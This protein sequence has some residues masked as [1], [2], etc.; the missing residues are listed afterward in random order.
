MVDGWKSGRGGVVVGME[1][2][3]GEIIENIEDREFRLE[4][5]N[6]RLQTSDMTLAD[7]AL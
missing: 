5:S 3:G 1:R 6:G 2:V 7:E 4:P